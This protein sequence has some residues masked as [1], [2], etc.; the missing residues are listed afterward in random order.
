MDPGQIIRDY[1]IVPENCSYVKIT[2][3]GHVD[4]QH[5]IHWRQVV[6]GSSTNQF[7]KRRYPKTK[8]QET[9]DHADITHRFRVQARSIL[10]KDKS[11]RLV[12]Y[13][14]VCPGEILELVAGQ[15]WLN[16]QVNESFTW[17][18]EF[19]GINVTNQ[20]LHLSHGITPIE[21]IP[22]TSESITPKLELTHVR[23]PLAPKSVEISPLD[24]EYDRPLSVY[25]KSY[26]SDILYEFE[27]VEKAEVT[28][29]QW[30]IGGACYESIFSEVSFHR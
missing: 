25:H 8:G 30:I 13:D 21:L 14:D 22:A 11:R 10:V 3:D 1:Y 18:I 16:N 28:L 19:G 12:Y 2:V 15:F 23:V 5:V 26:Q 27:L 9:S 4:G 6:E 7:V 17:S 29:F 24:H 20:P